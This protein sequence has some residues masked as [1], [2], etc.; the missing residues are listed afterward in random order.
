MTTIPVLSIHQLMMLRSLLAKG[1]EAS[2]IDY[3]PRRCGAKEGEWE[4]LVDAGLVEEKD[5]WFRL[6]KLGKQEYR[7]QKVGK[8]F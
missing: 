1:W 8:W 5:N 2:L 4:A 7:R 6:T 3:V